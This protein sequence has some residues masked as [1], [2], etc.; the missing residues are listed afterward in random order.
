MLT[1]TG[2]TL[3]GHSDTILMPTELDVNK[4]MKPD[5][6]NG[7]GDDVIVILCIVSWMEVN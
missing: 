7:N 5:N 6:D 2:L 1:L 4:V 3:S